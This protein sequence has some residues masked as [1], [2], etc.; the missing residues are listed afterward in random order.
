MEQLFIESR[1]RKYRDERVHPSEVPDADLV[2]GLTRQ[3]EDSE[4]L[5]IQCG[6]EVCRLNLQDSR[7]G[8]CKEDG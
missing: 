5:Q 7:Q 8:I 4:D 2:N 3:A 6:V 1:G